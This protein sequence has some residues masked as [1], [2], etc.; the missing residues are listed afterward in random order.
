[1]YLHLISDT[2]SSVG[3]L[4]GG[5]AIKLWE[6]V[7]VDP[8]VTILIALYVA[9]ETIEVIKKTINILMQSA[10]PLDLAAIQAALMQVEKV[11]N[12]HHG[13]SW[14][15]DETAIHFEGNIDLADMLLSEVEKV[16]A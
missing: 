13:Q 8:L 14:M 3:V 1:S 16:Y 2:I 4:A 12:I 9:K 7:W 11:K 10:P 5:I 6:I 15:V